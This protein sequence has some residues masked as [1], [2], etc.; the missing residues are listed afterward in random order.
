M[1]NIVRNA[2]RFSPAGTNLHID[3]R[4]DAPG[5]IRLQ[6]ADHGEGVPESELEAIFTPFYRGRNLAT[7]DGY[8]LG[9]AIARQVITAINGKIAAKRKP[10]G[11]SGLL[12]D[13]VLPVAD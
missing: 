11:S 9:L 8:G 4:L 2:L 13:I 1:E 12:I 6:I 5:K 7:G 10:D 3:A